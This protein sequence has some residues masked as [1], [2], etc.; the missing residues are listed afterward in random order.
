MQGAVEKPEF[1][2]A[3]GKIAV[4]VDTMVAGRIIVG[5]A[6]SAG[7]AI[8]CFAVPDAFSIGSRQF[9]QFFHF[10]Q[11][12]CVDFAAPALFS[13]R[14]LKGFINQVLPGNHEIYEPLQGIGRM[15]CAVHMDMDAAAAVCYSTVFPELPDDFLKQ[16]DIFIIQR[17]SDHFNAVFIKS[18]S[19][20][21]ISG[22]VDRT[23][24]HYFSFPAGRVFD[25]LCVVDVSVCL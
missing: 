9:R 10:F 21:V 13:L 17:G 6:D 16:V 1:N 25:Y 12:I 18:F 24:P 22:T 15:V 4:Q 2:S 7:I 5:M 3:F 14:N 20:A 11:D 23:V 19:L 8:V